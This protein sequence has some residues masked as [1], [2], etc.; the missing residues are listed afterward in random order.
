MMYRVFESRIFESPALGRCLLFKPRTSNLQP[1]NSVR[2]F[3]PI[4]ILYFLPMPPVGNVTDKSPT[5]I[6]AQSPVEP[7]APAAFTQKI[8]PGLILTWS[9]SLVVLYISKW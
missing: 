1:L 6:S 2:E 4:L 5:K 3:R 7:A 8:L 9:L